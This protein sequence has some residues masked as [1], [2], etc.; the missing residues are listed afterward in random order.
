MNGIFFSD[1]AFFLYF[2]NSIE[3]LIY[4]KNIIPDAGIVCVHSSI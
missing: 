4:E 3:I 2:S 1:P